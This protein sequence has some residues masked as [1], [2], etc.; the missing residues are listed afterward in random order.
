MSTD[1]L[2]PAKDALARELAV[3]HG[4]P[5]KDYFCK[6]CKRYHMEGSQAAYDHQ[7]FADRPVRIEA[8][9]PVTELLREAL[10]DLR[11]SMRRSR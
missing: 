1:P 7:R 10:L 11:D 2:A 9:S 8:P 6:K 4:A 5:S 3:A